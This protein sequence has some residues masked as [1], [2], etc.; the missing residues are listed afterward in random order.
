M[1]ASANIHTH[2]H[3]H[4]Y[5]QTLKLKVLKFQKKKQ[6][7]EQTLKFDKKYSIFVINM[8]A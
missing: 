1:L 3:T 2:T 4:T 6:V 7:I 5:T 8:K